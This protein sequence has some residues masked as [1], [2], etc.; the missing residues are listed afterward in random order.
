M[1]RGEQLLLAVGLSLAVL[2]VLVLAF[3]NHR[4]AVLE[5]HRAQQV[6]LAGERRFRSL[7]EGSVQG[8]IIHRAMRP[9]F[10]NQAFATL[11]GMDSPGEILRLPCIETL[12]APHERARLRGYAEARMQGLEAP[13]QYEFEAL[14]QDGS[15]VSLETVVQV[16]DWEGQPAVQ[17]TMVDITRRKQAE[18][19]LLE[20][21]DAAEAAVYTK[22][23]FLATVSHELRTPM[24]GVIGMTGLL[25]DTPL[26]DE[27]REYTETIRRCGDDMLTLINDVLDFSKIE[28]GK[29][30]LERIDFDLRLAVEDVLELFAESAAAK[31]LEL[32]CVIH[33]QVPTGVVGDPGRL[34]Q[35][36]T[37]LVGNA[38]KFTNTGEIVVRASCTE[39]TAEEALLRFTVSDSGI[40]IPPE[41]QGRLFQ[42]FTQADT[43]TTRKYGGTG[44][45]LAIC[46]QLAEIMGGAIGVDSVPNQG[47]TFWFTVRLRKGTTSRPCQEPAEFDLH[48]LHVLCVDD[49]ATNRTLL[50]MQLSAWGMQVDGLADGANALACLQAAQR[51]GTPYVLAILDMQMP[52]LDGLEVAR[53]IRAHPELAAVRLIMLSAFGQRAHGH[54]SQQPGIAAYLSKPV[55]QSQLYDTIVTV[56]HAAVEPQ[57]QLPATP[58]SLA[59]AP[60]GGRLRVLLA[61]DNIVNQRLAV[62]LLEKLGCRVDTVASGREAVEALSHLAYALVFMDCQM[63]EMDGYAATAAIREREA[64]TGSHTP[65]IAMTANAMPGDR[66]RCLQ[67]G[68]DDYVSKPIKTADLAE[69]LRKWEQV[70][71][72]VNAPLRDA[73]SSSPLP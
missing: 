53:M 32:L 54:A 8:M 64:M 56:L 61:E 55:R 45:G 60:A 29:L 25:L 51:A 68:M 49:N 69:M 34:R 38:V 28:A 62:R 2:T 39:D 48:G 33:P 21:K 30:D 65:I 37:N 70:P 5:R 47:S 23:R 17:A 67:A 43:S 15:L 13:S 35:I 10:V 66:E 57:P 24:N 12:F 16:I 20:A 46:R 14:R 26:N 27:Q 7:I 58:H 36:L 4:L 6:M 40:G 42:A 59:E 3:R 71:L 72:Q 11:L 52:S 73:V 18:A 50:E 22:S 9:L 31:N 44:L 1:I 63:P 19:A 41:V